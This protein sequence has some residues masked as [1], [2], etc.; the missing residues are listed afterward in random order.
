MLCLYE[1]KIKFQN[2][3]ITVLGKCDADDSI[4]A[5]WK[6]PNQQLTPE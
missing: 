2:I 3:V 4:L 1:C 5:F 6:L